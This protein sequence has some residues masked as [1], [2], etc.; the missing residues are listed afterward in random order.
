MELRGIHHITAIASD[1]QRNLDFYT[2]MLGLRLVKRTVNFDDPSTYHFYFG[3]RTGRPGTVIT[4]FPWPGARRGSRGVGQVVATSFAIPEGAIDCWRARF[5]EQGLW[6][7][8]TSPRFG[9]NVLRLA[10]PDGLLI[11]LITSPQLED[12]DLTYESD[13]PNEFAIHAFHAPS[14]EMRRLARSEKLLAMLGFELI[15]EENGRRRFAVNT[16]LVAQGTD[17]RRR[18]S[19][20]IDIIERPDGGFGVNSVG[21]VHHIAFRCGDKAEQ[22][23]WR[24]RIVDLGLYVTPVIDRQY[25][26]SIYFREPNGILFEVATDGPGFAADEPV[27]HLGETLKLPPQYEPQRAEIEGILPPIECVLKL[28][29]GRPAK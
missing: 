21:T 19:G 6:C 10:D 27:D 3:D 9:D 1:P 13:V 15:S 2:N 28:T 14:F 7:E 16:S 12:V 20:K 11:E 29:A 18:T 24:K 17:L 23:E 26:H 25:F 4:F 22:L 5:Q 8:Q